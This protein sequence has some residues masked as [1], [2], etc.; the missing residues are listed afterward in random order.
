MLA[1]VQIAWQHYVVASYSSV[2]FQQISNNRVKNM[3]SNSFTFLNKVT[4]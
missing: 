4:E 3:G 1:E 2:K